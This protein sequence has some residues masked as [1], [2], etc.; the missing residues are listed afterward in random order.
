MTDRRLI[1]DSLP[2]AE[3]SEQSAREKSLRIGNP[4]TLHIWWARRPLA[5]CRAAVYASLTPAP[6]TEDERA[7]LHTAVE[8]LSNW[9]NHFPDSDE[10]SAIQG[11]RKELAKPDRKPRVLDPFSG[12]G[13]IP[14]AALELGCETYA[15]DLNPVA[16]V[17][18]LATLQFN[19]RF[20]HLDVAGTMGTSHEG[21]RQASIFEAPKMSLLG[22]AVKHWSDVVEER[23]LERVAGLYPASDGERVISYI[24]A[25]TVE[26][27][28]PACRCEIPLVRQLWLERKRKGASTAL[29]MIPNKQENRVDFE[30]ETAEELSFDPR[31]GTVQRGNA[32]CQLCGQVTAAARLRE[33]GRDGGIG[34]RLLCVVADRIGTSGK[35][36]RLPNARDLQALQTASQTAATLRT[37]RLAS[38]VAVIPDES[39]P[40]RGTLGFRVNNYGYTSWGMLFNDR[41]LVTLATVCEIIRDSHEE[42]LQEYEFLGDAADDF[43]KAV[44][45]YLG[46]MQ[47]RLANYGSRQCM[48]LA[49]DGTR[50]TH[51]FGR[52]A[53]PMVWD[54]AESFP[55][56]P[57]SANWD[58][59]RRA[60]LKVLEFLPNENPCHVVRG[61]AD[62]LPFEDRFFDAVITDPPYYDAVP[63]SDLSDFFYVWHKRSFGFLYPDVYSTDLTPKRSE[64][65]ENPAHKKNAQH[66]EEGMLRSFREIHRVLREDGIAV[67]V[68]AHKTTEAWE[69]LIRGL[70]E[71]GLV[72]TA[73]WPV[74]TEKPG[75]LR[76]QNSA[77]LA[78]SVF[79]VCRKR[80]AHHDG[81]LDDVEPDLK[82]RLHERLDYFWSQGIRGA[83]FFMSAIGPAVEVFGRY[84]RVMRLSGEEVTVGDLLERVRGIVADYALQRIVHGERAGDVDEASRFYVIWRWAF[85]ATD[86]ESG[87]AIHMAQSLGCEIGELLGGKGVL[88]QK[89]AKVVLRGPNERKSV[90]GLGEP[91]STGVLAP[92][93]DVLHRAAN[94]WAAGERQDLADFLAESL[95]PGGVD[96]MQRLA[97]SIVD[98][99][100]PGDKERALYE[101]FLVGSRSLPAPTK[102]DSSTANQQKLF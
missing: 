68:F 50:T 56:N 47:A 24:W 28:N 3:I 30:V 96:R 55:F 94:F 74:E 20:G 32:V 10:F 29:K 15:L 38:G 66:F 36:F 80:S 82:V 39:L 59:A 48:W 73:S 100:V 86:V 1:E 70:L 69:T 44:T 2:L 26:C 18:E 98:V 57:L 89:G 78:S 14:L 53:L 5:A 62:R 63:Y 31:E 34:E 92:L 58:K 40:P 4:S 17:I 54:Y 87:E 99:L 7:S 60:V 49:V 19:Q 72:V 90:K 52:Q 93:V 85:G 76:A 23:A 71:S 77:A 16:H 37:K 75:R 12:G 88:Q 41:Q 51:T 11:I 79:I 91:S 13:T 46:I 25:R 33:I 22:A 84:K 35:K 43:A 97:Q 101:N 64:I 8:K 65:V 6:A 95:P 81:F 42:R 102:K 45:T 21:P 27:T 83:D 61:S 9:N 67:V